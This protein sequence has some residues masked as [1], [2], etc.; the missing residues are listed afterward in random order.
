M[1]EKMAKIVN[2]PI[3][4]NSLKKRRQGIKRVKLST[5]A[6]KNPNF[7]LSAYQTIHR[8]KLNERLLRTL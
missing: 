4:I 5:V 7:K 3:D 6:K 1:I 8:A 2:C